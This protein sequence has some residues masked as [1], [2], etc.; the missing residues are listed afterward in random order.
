MKI[1]MRSTA[2]GPRG[3]K[4][5]GKVYDVDEA[6]GRELVAAGAAVAVPTPAAP[7]KSAPAPAAGPEADVEVAAVEAREVAAVPGRR[8]G[9][10]NSR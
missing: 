4:L 10:Q 6:E 2:C 9:R 8:K 1:R 5:C 7:A 3:N